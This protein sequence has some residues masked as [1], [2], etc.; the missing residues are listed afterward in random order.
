[1]IEEWR[2]KVGFLF[3]VLLFS[4]FTIA[5]GGRT[6]SSGGHRCSSKSIAKGVCS[7]YHYH[8]S[9]SRKSNL[10]IPNKTQATNKSVPVV[11][12]YSK[13]YNRK[14]WSHWVDNDGDCQN[15]RAE[16]LIA[17][18]LSAVTYRNKK[19]CSVILGNWLDPFSGKTWFK[20][21]DVD[22]DHIVPLKWAHGHGAQSWTRD[23]KKLFANDWENLLVVEDNLNQTKGAKSPD[24]WMPPNQAFRCEYVEMFNKIVKKYELQYIPSEKRIIDRMLSKCH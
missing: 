3:V 14:E 15:T 13:L 9:L 2:V 24:D 20:A 4:G 8:E 12:P 19:Q 6:D 16:I 1:L 21:S 17:R 18:S 22:I 5:H 11:G 7:G 23:R 10:E